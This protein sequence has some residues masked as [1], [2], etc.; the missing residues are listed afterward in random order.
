M[1]AAESNIPQASA[2]LVLTLRLLWIATQLVAVW[3]CGQRGVTFFY[4]QF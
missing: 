4:Q 1:V 3:Y 2:R